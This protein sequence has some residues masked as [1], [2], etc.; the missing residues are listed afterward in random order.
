MMSS[1]QIH[2]KNFPTLL[3][4]TLA[5]FLLCFIYNKE[6]LSQGNLTTIISGSECEYIIGP[7]VNVIRPVNNS[8]IFQL[9]EGVNTGRV[10]V[11]CHI[12]QIHLPGISRANS[13]AGIIKAVEFDTARICESGSSTGSIGAAYCGDSEN[14][15]EPDGEVL[16][17]SS[18]RPSDTTTASI[19]LLTILSQPLRNTAVVHSAAISWRLQ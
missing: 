4:H 8:L 2:N 15:S 18:V 17:P 3:A 5:I 14:P 7:G 12:P 13:I 19:I 10:E 16:D 1:T 9:Q 11:H 6:V